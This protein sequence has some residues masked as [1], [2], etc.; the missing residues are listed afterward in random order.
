[1]PTHKRDEGHEV[2]GSTIP[3]DGLILTE[4]ITQGRIPNGPSFQ[5]GT[6]VG[7]LQGDLLL[8]VTFKDGEVVNERLDMGGMLQT[9]I[10]EINHSKRMRDEFGA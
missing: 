7:N 4:T 2:Q 3:D 6:I 1:M 8:T 9:W 10:S 5:L